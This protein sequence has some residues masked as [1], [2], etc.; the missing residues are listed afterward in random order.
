MEQ[1]F[2]QD[3]RVTTEI[4][5]LKTPFK[6]AL[7]TVSE[8]ENIIVEIVLD[9]GVTGIGAAAPLIKIGIVG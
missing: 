9:N 7:R 5:P 4:L 2:I 6:T 3:L 1:L 8:I